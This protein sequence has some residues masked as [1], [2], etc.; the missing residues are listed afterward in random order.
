MVSLTLSG[1]DTCRP[2][3]VCL[4]PSATHSPAPQGDQGDLTADLECGEECKEPNM[5]AGLQSTGYGYS[6]PGGVALHL[7]A[8]FEGV[9]RE[10]IRFEHT[11]VGYLYA[12]LG[13][14]VCRFPSLLRLHSRQGIIEKNGYGILRC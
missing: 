12:R 10:E 14:T 1:H 7:D 11:K 2:L 4:S 9:F 13:K 6:P 8:I 5:S 3:S